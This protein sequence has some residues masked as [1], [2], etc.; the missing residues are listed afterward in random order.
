MAQ[1]KLRAQLGLGA[2]SKKGEWDHLA[3]YIDQSMR[4]SI[5]TSPESMPPITHQQPSFDNLVNLITQNK[6]DYF[7]G[8][9]RIKALRTY[10]S[11]RINSKR[12]NSRRKL[13]RSGR[14][15]SSGRGA[16][17][18]LAPQTP[19]SLSDPVHDTPPEPAEQ[20]D[21]SPP[22]D[23][24]LA[25]QTTPSMDS[26]HHTLPESAEQSRILP[27]RDF[28]HVPHAVTI[29]ASSTPAHLD[30]ASTQQEGG[31]SRLIPSCS[32]G[33]LHLQT[34]KKEE[35]IVVP[36]PSGFRRY[37]YEPAVKKEEIVDE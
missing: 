13:D 32:D 7:F 25:P 35:D 27:P 21:I 33:H 26:V 18:G 15:I 30:F 28:V 22:R 36:L 12:H 19:P 16:R 20:L 9:S 1:K 31:V 14:G 24:I 4:A 34:V 29:P 17:S 11:K 10:L 5:D 37:F 2:A 6:R 8:E 3:A 23:C